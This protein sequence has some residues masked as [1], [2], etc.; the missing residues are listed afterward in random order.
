MIFGSLKNV[1]LVQHIIP[2]EFLML[3]AQIIFLV[4]SMYFQYIY[5]N[6]SVHYSVI[7]NGTRDRNLIFG[8]SLNSLSNGPN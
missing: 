5:V 8:N 1:F 3:Q 4:A 7:Q 6:L 2:S